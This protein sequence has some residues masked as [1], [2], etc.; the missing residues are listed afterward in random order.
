LVGILLGYFLH[1]TKG[2]PF[3]IPKIVA[4]ILWVLAITIGLLVVYGVVPYI[5]PT[6]VQHIDDGIR[7]AYGSLNRFAWAIAVAW[8]ILAC[9]KGYGSQFQCYYNILF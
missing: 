1:S 5:N 2:K 8:V 6:K 4:G 7:V 3:K 9:V